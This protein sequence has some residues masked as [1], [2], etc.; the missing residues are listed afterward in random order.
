MAEVLIQV[1]KNQ[2][3]LFR[4]GHD[5]DQVDN[6]LVAEFPYGSCGDALEFGYQVNLIRQTNRDQTNITK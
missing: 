3:Q 2:R 1:L 5:V 6:V 4:V